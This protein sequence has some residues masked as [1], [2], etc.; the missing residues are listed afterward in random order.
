MAPL[1]SHVGDNEMQP[2]LEGTPQPLQRRAMAL[3]AELAHAKPCRRRL[4]LVALVSL[5]T[6]SPLR[7]AMALARHLF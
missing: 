2:T 6:P 1:R 4:F 3:T 7:A 5:V